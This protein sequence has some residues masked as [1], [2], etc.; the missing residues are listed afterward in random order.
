M[1]VLVEEIEG[2]L[3]NLFST[4]TGLEFI[5]GDDNGP[6]PVGPYGM[7]R[8]TDMG[9][10]GLW[11]EDRNE[12]Q[13]TEPDIVETMVG[14]RQLMVSTNAYRG[15][16]R[17]ELS[18]IISGLQRS[19]STAWMNERKLSLATSSNIRNLSQLEEANMEQRAQVDI[20]INTTS[21]DSEVVTAIESI[22]I[23]MVAQTP[24]QSIQ[25]EIEVNNQ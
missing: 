12:N 17:T 3:T 7:L 6:V 22:T 11:D 15:N 25:T 13:A 18:K 23:E 1:T 2:E 8:V 16:A 9:P 21:T 10:N 24:N 5:V 19:S 20:F 4:I 14:N